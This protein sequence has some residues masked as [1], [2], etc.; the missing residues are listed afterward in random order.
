[1]DRRRFQR[2]MLFT[3]GL[4]VFGSACTNNSKSASKNVPTTTTTS[5]RVTTPTLPNPLA[6]QSCVEATR[7]QTALIRS[8]AKNAYFKRELPGINL[9]K[10]I[11]SEP[12]DFPTLVANG[13][14][15]FY[16][17]IRNLK[18]GNGGIT[19]STDAQDPSSGA[20][21]GSVSAFLL[22]KLVGIRGTSPAVIGIV[23][24]LV[25]S[26]TEYIPRPRLYI[27]GLI[28]Q[29]QTEKNGAV[30]ARPTLIPGAV[31]VADDPAAVPDIPL[32][33]PA[34]VPLLGMRLF[35][36]AKYFESLPRTRGKVFHFSPPDF[37]EAFHCAAQPGPVLTIGLEAAPSA[38]G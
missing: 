21:L 8:V 14:V 18:L 34:N 23:N 30:S 17:Q 27:T 25:E 7:E 11:S 1:M 29:A 31:F 16:G 38:I 13:A 6:P 22:A 4:S 3:A 33:S 35:E 2:T 37:L 26:Q 32:D 28:G 36:I 20:A 24:N 9:A 15:P 12:V 10:T 5:S 19:E